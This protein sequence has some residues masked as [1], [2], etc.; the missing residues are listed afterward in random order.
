MACGY[1]GATCILIG[2]MDHENG[3]YQKLGGFRDVDMAKD[4]ESQLDGTEDK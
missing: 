3:R 2:N 1:C 4:G